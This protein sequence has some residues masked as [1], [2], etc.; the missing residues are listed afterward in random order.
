MAQKKPTL[1]TTVSR[2]NAEKIASETINNALARDVADHGKIV[3]LTVSR[4][5]YYLHHKHYKTDVRK[6]A[7]LVR[8]YLFRLYDLDPEHRKP[9]YADNLTEN[10]LELT[11]QI[12]NAIYNARISRSW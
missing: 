12:A 3:D 1:T 7:T 6:A 11:E 2:K 10:D 4:N 5:P 9:P 8:N